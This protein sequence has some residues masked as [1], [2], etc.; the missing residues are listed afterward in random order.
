MPCAELQPARRV[1]AEEVRGFGFRTRC[2]LGT[3]AFLLSVAGLSAQQA[4]Y[5]SN[6]NPEWDQVSPSSSSS[7]GG[8]YA[9][10][11]SSSGSYSSSGYSSSAGST[12]GVRVGSRSSTTSGAASLRTAPASNTSTR[13]AT[14]TPHINS[15]SQPNSSG[16]SDYRRR[17]NNDYRARCPGRDPTCRPR[18]PGWPIFLS[19]RVVLANGERP[20]ELVRIV[21]SC[22]GRP[23][24]QVYADAKGRFYFQP[25]CRS[26]LALADASIRGFSPY[27]SF[28]QG[29]T[30]TTGTADLMGCVLYAEVPGFW[31]SRIRLGLVRASKRNDVGVVVLQP[32]RGST[33]RSVSTTTL[34][35]PP[36][37]KRAY[38]IGITALRKTQSFGKAAKSF[39][40]AVEIHPQHAQAWAGLGEARAA[41]G[42]FDGAQEAFER[43]IK[44]DPNLL[45]PY[46]A[47]M[48]IAYDQRDWQQLDTLAAKYLEL[49]PGSSRARFYSSL[50]ALHLDDLSRTEFIIKQMQEL[51]ETDEWPTSHV[52]MAVVHERRADFEAAADYY[53]KYIEIS[54]DAE[55][56]SLVRRAIYD[57]G[58]LQ[59]IEPRQVTLAQAASPE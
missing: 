34:T 57:W 2:W 20:N 56:S 55:L 49:A 22:G 45:Q 7:Y 32:L 3:A 6:W 8:S 10:P 44:A 14:A 11:S 27:T 12:Y 30:T 59:V 19:G 31:S 39:Q 58:E 50:A 21:V 13:Q 24:P 43:S 29:L 23:I 41:L 40:R 25:Q 38:R 4:S 28:A 15:S 18:N 42:D 5:D 1:G 16:D 36:K 17:A 9:T 47:M 54:V 51:G 26:L 53:E 48:P 35:A 33:G 52:I 46:D 37:A